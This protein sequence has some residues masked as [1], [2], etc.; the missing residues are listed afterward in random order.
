MLAQTLVTLAM[1]AIFAASA[2]AGVAG[3]ARARTAAAA[4][5]SIVPAVQTALARYQQQIAAAVGAQVAANGDGSLAAPQAIPALNGATAWTPMHDVEAVAGTALSV[6]VDIVP[7]S[8]TVPACA[9]TVNAGPDTA[10]ADQC[11]PFVQESRLALTMTADAG[12][13]DAA[14]AVAS[15]AHGRTTVTLRLFA[16][17]P[18]A[19]VSGTN[20]AAAPDA[21]HEGDV[22]GYGNAL[23]DFGPAPAPGDTTIHVLYA[24]M[25]ANG[26]CAAS[27]PPPADAPTA[28]PWTNANGVP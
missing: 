9:S 17:P 19:I 14:G 1:M 11:S 25:P 6:A 24:C 8:P 15:L 7:A 28:I 16:Q 27:A 5:A 23:L 13:A 2:V 12:P 20:D 3:V 26:S 18:Y 22:A 4:K 10:Q 21:P